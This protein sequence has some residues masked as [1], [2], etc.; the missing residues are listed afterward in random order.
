MKLINYILSFLFVLVSL[1]SLYLYFPTFMNYINSKDIKDNII[2]SISLDN[3]VPVS[4]IGSLVNDSDN[5]YK[6]GYTGDEYDFDTLYYPYYGLLGDEYKKLY[7]QIYANVVNYNTDFKPIIDINN[8]DISLVIESVIYDHPEL[9]WL[10]NSFSYKYN[11][12]F[13]CIQINLKFNNLY[14]DIENNKIIFESE[15]EKI[16][17]LTK[18]ATNDYDKEKIVHDYL[19]KNLSY[20]EKSINNQS[21]YSAIVTKNSVCAGYSKA[22]Q[23]ILQKINIPCYYVTGYSYG[24]HAWNMVKID[25]SYYNVDVT[26]DNTGNNSYYYFN[27]SDSDF[28]SS[29]TRSDLSNLLPKCYSVNLYYRESYSY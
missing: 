8:D 20:D 14:D 15:V 28:E 12:L 3:I 24:D 11:N 7:R 17:D 6:I 10:D 13:K 29:H 21:A 9:F 18:N 26:W 4:G 2:K 22:F 19:V 27:K 16:V 5:N 1:L 23:Y 25:N